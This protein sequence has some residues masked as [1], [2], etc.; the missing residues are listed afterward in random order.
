MIEWLEGSTVQLLA[1]GLKLGT[2][3]MYVLK[4]DAVL[5]KQF[6]LLCH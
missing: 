1:L 5:R 2:Q 4:N 6:P 3:Y